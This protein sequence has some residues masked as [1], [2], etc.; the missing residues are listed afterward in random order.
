MHDHVSGGAVMVHPPLM[1]HP[2]CP[3]PPLIMHPPKVWL[4]LALMIVSA[5]L[6]GWSD[7]RFNATGYS[8]Q[9]GVKGERDSRIF[10]ARAEKNMI[11]K[12]LDPPIGDRTSSTSASGIVVA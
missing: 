6:G 8:W 2:S 7:L 9:V 11:V 12:Y 5:A 10:F 3:A 4:C 1:L